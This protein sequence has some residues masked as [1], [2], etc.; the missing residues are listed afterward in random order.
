MTPATS[1]MVLRSVGGRPNS[2]V[3]TKPPGAERNGDAGDD[4]DDDEHHRLAACTSCSTSLRLRAERHPDADLV[5]APRHAVG[6]QAEEADRGDDERQ[7]AEECV[8]L[9]EELLLLRIAAR[10]ARAASRRRSPAGSDRSVG[11]ASRIALVTLVG[12]PAV[13]TSKTASPSRVCGNGTYIVGGAASRTLS[14][15]ASREHAHD[16]ELGP[17][18]PARS[19]VL[20][21]RDSRSGST[22]A[23]PLR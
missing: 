7:P 11:R 19:E 23:R 17:S 4:A 3:A 9:R 8:G 13:R 2:S 6:H 10:P 20:T 16:L 18:S 15:F 21:D 5:R 14:Y 22:C 12:T 1:A